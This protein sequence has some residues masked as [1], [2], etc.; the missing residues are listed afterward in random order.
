MKTMTVEE[1]LAM[2]DTDK[3]RHW[4]DSVEETHQPRSNDQIPRGEAPK[5][6]PEPFLAYSFKLIRT[7]CDK[8]EAERS[9]GEGS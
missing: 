5:G 6:I 2:S 1:I 4:C 3:V 7:L 9:S 8:L